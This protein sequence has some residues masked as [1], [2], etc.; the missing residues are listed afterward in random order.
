MTEHYSPGTEFAIDQLT[1]VGNTATY[2]DSPYH[3]FPSGTLL[4]SAG[5]PIVEHL[6]G[7]HQPATPGRRPVHG[8]ATTNRGIQLDPSTRVRATTRLIVRSAPH[9]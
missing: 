2:L 9:N 4:L 8:R 3:R 5:I 1:L 7:L 6:T